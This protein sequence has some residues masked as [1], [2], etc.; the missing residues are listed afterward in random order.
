MQMYTFFHTNMFCSSVRHTE[1]NS[2]KISSSSGN[3]SFSEFYSLNWIILKTFEAIKLSIYFWTKFVI[4]DEVHIH[5]QYRD[6]LKIICVCVSYN[7]NLFVLCMHEKQNFEVATHMYW[8]KYTHVCQLQMCEV[9]TL[10]VCSFN[11]LL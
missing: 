6:C 8:Y 2:D 9:Y 11:I 4:L 5:F 10:L 7:H 3:E 1:R